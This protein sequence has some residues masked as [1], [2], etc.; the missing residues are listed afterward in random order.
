MAATTA[1]WAIPYPQGSDRFC[2]GYLFTQQ[3]AERVDAIL[4]DFDVDLARTEVVPTARVSIS[5]ATVAGSDTLIPFDLVDWDNDNMVDLALANTTVTT[6][7]GAAMV[8]GTAVQFF[9]LGSASAT[10]S[11]ALFL[12][13]VTGVTEFEQRD[14]APGSAL[15]PMNGSAQSE[16]NATAGLTTG[17]GL[18]GSGSGDNTANYAYL[19]THWFSDAYP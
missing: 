16:V 2:D 18:N 5:A 8:A 19:W 4:D 13:H 3:M 14:N 9:N 10:N 6:P 7:V 1:T 11:Y 17:V 12:N 15:F